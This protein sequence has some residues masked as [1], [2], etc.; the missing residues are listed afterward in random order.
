[1]G[2]ADVIPGVSGGTM[3]F[4]TGIYEEF[5]Y[6]INEIDTDAFRLLVKFQFSQCWKKINGNFLATVIAGIVTSLL[7]LSG[8]MLSL[9]RNHTVTTLSFFFGLILMAGPLLL[10][11]IKKWRANSILALLFGMAGAYVLTIL[12][13]AQIPPNLFFIFLS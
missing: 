5:V 13:P 12:S 7:L 3:A 10:R 1:M 4:I 9:W 6:S 8:V 2:A 11:S